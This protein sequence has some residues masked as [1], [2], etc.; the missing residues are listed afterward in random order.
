MGSFSNFDLSKLSLQPCA[1]VNFDPRVILTLTNYPKR[2]NHLTLRVVALTP[3]IVTF[4]HNLGQIHNQIV[5]VKNDPALVGA[6]LTVTCEV[7]NDPFRV[8]LT[9]HL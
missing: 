1:G 7:K 5:G 8:I 9:P 2:V 6:Y 3:H 4:N